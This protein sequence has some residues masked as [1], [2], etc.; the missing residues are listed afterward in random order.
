MQNNIIYG[1]IGNTAVLTVYLHILLVKVLYL[2]K[3]IFTFYIYS[4]D[5]LSKDF[6][7][8]EPPYATLE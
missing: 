6:L 8:E 5:F 1:K 7:H 3:P 4:L 2:V